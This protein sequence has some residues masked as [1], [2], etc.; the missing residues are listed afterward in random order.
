MAISLKATRMMMII[1]CFPINVS[2]SANLDM[3]KNGPH[4]TK[5]YVS[6]L[7]CETTVNLI[8]ILINPIAYLFD[9]E[10]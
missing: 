5:H 2:F 4:Q 3:T 7:L 1:Y 6:K 9:T 8:L 10:K